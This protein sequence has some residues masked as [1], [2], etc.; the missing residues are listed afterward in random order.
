M[1]VWSLHTFFS[2]ACILMF[3][4]NVHKATQLMK[5]RYPELHFRKTTALDVAST[6]I[7][8]IVVSVCP[9]FN[10]FMLYALMFKDEALIESAVQYA[11]DKFKRERKSKE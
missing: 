10:L 1:S 5:E 6:A 11:Y 9:I 7:K 8:I 2:I 4:I 3:C